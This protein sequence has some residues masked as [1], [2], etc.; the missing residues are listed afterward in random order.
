[1]GN[2]ITTSPNRAAV[3]SGP[4]G[5]RTIIG[6]CG[7][8]IYCIEACEYL[9]LELMTLEINST[10]SETIKGVRVNCGA[11]AQIKVKALDIEASAAASVEG[12]SHTKYDMA[13]VTV[14]ATHFLGESEETIR[15]SIL[16]TMEGHQRQ[17][18]GTLTVE[19][20][21][22]DRSA[23]SQRIRLLVEGDLLAM[24]FQ[25][26]SYTVTSIDDE[27]GY[28][29][30][31]GATQTA[32]V[33]RE[34][35]EGKARN[36]AEGRKKVAQWD[37]DAE[38]AT[39]EAT[40]E[41]HVVVNLQ[42]QAEAESDRDLNLKKASYETQVNRANAEAKAAGEIENAKQQQAVI[43]ERTQQEVVAAQVRLEI[44]DREVE[45][46][47]KEKDGSSLADLMEERNKGEA[48]RV[49]AT[50]DADRIRMIGQAEAGAREA[51]GAAEAAVLE[52]KAEA[53]KLYGDA[54]MVQMVMDKMPELA[55][56]M[57]AP[58]ANTKEMVFVSSDGAAGS[59]LTND[60]SKMLS[61]LPAT[62]KGL[63]GVDIREMVRDKVAQGSS[64]DAARADRD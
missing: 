29:E 47:K 13:S 3:I 5:A 59:A 39:A 34:A 63:T 48:I 10:S 8:Q 52:K 19:E 25:L 16:R 58:L 51:A 43:R 23:F 32:L 22:K 53:W 31:L 64:R 1:M 60:I 6:G 14:A 41:A 49:I 2:I 57:A 37:A 45:R 62:V 55:A 35:A 11:V 21:Y 56:N 26:V 7:F 61:Q 20:I 38:K 54:A 9:S 4:W 30:S 42:K 27:N 36:Q 50:A 17:I 12:R 24:G 15:D 40:K 28:M 46:M 18:L 44:T 33:K